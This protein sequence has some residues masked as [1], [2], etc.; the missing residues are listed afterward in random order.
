MNDNREVIAENNRKSNM[1]EITKRNKK[2]FNKIREPGRELATN[3]EGDRVR[4][5]R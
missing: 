3:F 5:L 1:N 4:T 2:A